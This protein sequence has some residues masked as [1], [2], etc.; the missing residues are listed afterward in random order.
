[1]NYRLATIKAEETFTSDVTDPIDIDVANPIS[2]LII[3]LQPKTGSEGDS[4]GHPIK[5]LKK[6]ELVD[7]SDV[8]FSL[9][10]PEAHALDWYSSLIERTNIIW[11]LPESVMDLALHINFGRYLWDPDLAFDP[12]KFTNPQLKITL[13][14][15]GG[16]MNNSQVTTSVFAHIFDE[17][18]VTPSGF[19]MAKEIK[20]Y[21]LGSAT[22]EYTDM[23]TDFPY[24]KL[25]LRI[26][27][28]ATGLEYCF[29]NIK[30]TEDVDKRIPLNHDIR[31]I[32]HAI[33]AQQRPY[34]ES[35]IVGGGSTERQFHITPAYWPMMAAS[36]WEGSAISTHATVWEGD[37]GRA[38]LF[39]S[40][41]G[42][43]YSVLIEGWCPHGVV[44]IPFG[45]QNDM[46][47][48]F[49]VTKIGSLKLDVLSAS[50]MSSSES[51]QVFIQQ[52]RRY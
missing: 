25:L 28:D 51:C 43:N 11:Y 8:L 7:G 36:H 22:H 49:D 39:T 23:P 40:G 37:G 35:V 17:K 14:I 30:L 31:E 2:Q 16:G 47:D 46:G 15:D 32:L 48:W 29:D 4:D 12:R 26:Q 50:G 34:R 6:I 44:E 9:S 21:A 3:R 45:V 27:K 1:M 13:D 38:R 20:D 33:T 24:R 42:G 18:A 10:G 19:L 52:L 41:V 5:C